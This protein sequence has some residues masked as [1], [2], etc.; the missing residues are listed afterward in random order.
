[1]RELTAEELILVSG[2][3]DTNGADEN[4]GDDI[5]HDPGEHPDDGMAHDPGDVSPGDTVSF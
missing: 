5:S 4:W 2:G 3:D 1:M